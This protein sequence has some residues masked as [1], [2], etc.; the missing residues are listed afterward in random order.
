M[1]D[2]SDLEKDVWVATDVLA[3]F[4]PPHAE[5]WVPE[6]CVKGHVV[7]VGH[8]LRVLLFHDLED[9]EH[10]VEGAR[11]L[12]VDSYATLALTTRLECLKLC[13]QLLVLFLE[14]LELGGL[15]GTLDMS[16]LGE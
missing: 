2:C 15:F 12:E 1:N 8:A 5:E 9:V 7:N 10:R 6:F 13:T 4:T 3:L 14:L 11:T 16:G